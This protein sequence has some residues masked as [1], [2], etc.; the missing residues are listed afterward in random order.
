[1]HK[2]YTLQNKKALQTAKTTH[3]SIEFA[4]V[5]NISSSPCTLS[6]RWSGC[7][8]AAV[9]SGHLSGRC[10]PRRD[11]WRWAWTALISVLPPSWIEQRPT[12]LS[13]RSPRCQ[14][15]AGSWCFHSNHSHGQRVDESGRH[16]FR[17]V[18]RE[19][20]TET[21][22]WYSCSSTPSCFY[23]KFHDSDIEPNQWV[24]THSCCW[25]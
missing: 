12:H 2:H 3:A 24:G 9:P 8:Q 18:N 15:P 16:T 22:I 17:C 14:V 5:A 19:S 10:D 1:M 4:T 23:W 13:A 25:F 21:E 20:D 6:P 7:L 11:W